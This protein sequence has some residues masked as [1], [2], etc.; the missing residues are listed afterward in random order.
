MSNLV[1]VYN[2]LAQNSEKQWMDNVPELEFF[3]NVA[4]PIHLSLQCA[5]A[6]NLVTKLGF[7]GHFA[8]SALGKQ[9][10]NAEFTRFSAVRTPQNLLNPFLGGSARIR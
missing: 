7:W 1:V 2:C 6:K 9:P 3:C 4:C 8:G 5:M 10:Q